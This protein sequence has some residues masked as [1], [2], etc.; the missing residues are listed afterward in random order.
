M[1]REKGRSTCS[2]SRKY[3]DRRGANPADRAQ[4]LSGDPAATVHVYRQAG[5]P[6][7]LRDNDELSGEDMV[8]GFTCRVSELF[9]GLGP[10]AIT[11]P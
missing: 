11:G 6:S 5:A 3:P 8:E 4:F 10:A 1:A 7:T 9:E 2:Y